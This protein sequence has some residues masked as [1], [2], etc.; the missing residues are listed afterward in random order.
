M[1]SLL[2]AGKLDEGLE[3]QD[4]GLEYLLDRLDVR[5]G[6]DNPSLKTKWNS[7]TGHMAYLHDTEYDQFQVS[8]LASRFRGLIS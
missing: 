7:L 3:D 6:D 1:C 2:H 4:V 8:F 5:D